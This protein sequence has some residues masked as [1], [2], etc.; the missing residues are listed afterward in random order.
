MTAAGRHHLQLYLMTQ[1]R[2]WLTG[3]TIFAISCGGA[4]QLIPADEFRPGYGDTV[5][6]VAWPPGWHYRP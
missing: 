4:V 5:E 3:R 6:F 2:A 1:E